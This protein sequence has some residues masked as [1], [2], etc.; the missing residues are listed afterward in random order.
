MAILSAP[1]LSGLSILAILLGWAGLYVLWR[2]ALLAAAYKAKI[3]ASSV[4]VARRKP[5]AV[6]AEDLAVD[7]LA[8]LKYVQTQIDW[9]AQT[10]TAS[11]LGLARR[12]VIYR[13]GLGCTLVV[14]IPEPVIRQQPNPLGFGAS[15]SK[16]TFEFPIAS[17]LPAHVQAEALDS[18]IASA[19]EESNPRR[20][21]RSRA[22]LVVQA[23]EIIAERY[24]PGFTA[25]TPFLGWSMAKSVVNA[26]IG[27]LVQQGKLALDTYSLVADCNE[28]GD[29]CDQITLDQLLR[30]SSGL[31]FSEIYSNPLS[32]VTK[33]LFS[34]G[35]MAAYA[36]NRA[37]EEAPGV[38]W[39]YA[40]GTT[41]ILCQIIRQVVG[42]TA[43]DYFAFPH[44]ALF[45]PLGMTSAVLEPD[46]AGTFVGSSYLYAT[47][48]DWAKFG[49]LYLQDGVWRGERLLPEGWVAYSRT[50]APAAPQQQYGAHFWLKVPRSYASKRSP[51]PQMPAD[52][53]MASGYQGQLLTIIPSL[54]L[55]VAR[56]GLSQLR[57]SW[58]HEW[59]IE[60]LVKA[61]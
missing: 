25:E 3:L 9:Q 39:S 53:F 48:R 37:L 23:G 50:P 30:M 31:P 29:R 59:F 21:Q 24:A 20:L 16:S 47:A 17:G 43:A 44:R 60:R 58:D 27:I 5:E 46:A 15:Q 26:L 11:V 32:N 1:I 52:A 34:R 61:L 40:S 42:G 18:V 10:V 28:A 45:E 13:P 7:N 55:V 19:F 8:L 12:K 41:L 6:L 38:H 57:G 54:D 2:T 49:Q 51:R 22:V 56:F 36:A 35:D 33:M 4:F 14:D